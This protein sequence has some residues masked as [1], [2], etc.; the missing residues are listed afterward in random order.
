MSTTA[1]LTRGTPPPCARAPAP[2]PRANCAMCAKGFVPSGRKSSRKCTPQRGPQRETAAHPLLDSDRG[3]PTTTLPHPKKPRPGPCSPAFPLLPRPAAALPC[4]VPG[5]RHVL[6][7]IDGTTVLCCVAHAARAVTQKDGAGKAAGAGDAHTSTAGGADT[8]APAAAD[9]RKSKE[10]NKTALT[11]GET[12]QSIAHTSAYFVL[13][14]CRTAHGRAGGGSA[15]GSG[16][17]RASP[18]TKGA[19]LRRAAA[20]RQMQAAP[21]PTRLQRLLTRNACPM[22]CA[23]TPCRALS[24]APLHAPPILLLHPPAHHTRRRQR[25]PGRQ[26]GAPEAAVGPVDARAD[27]DVF[28]RHLAARQ[29]L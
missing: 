17:L 8:P 12:V 14:P 18:R 29:G 20:Q 28:R 24:A 1:S 7:S 5:Q 3:Y 16:S 15:V 23:C 13:A 4:P 2:A 10:M 21:P 9:G 22:L 25:G 11:D 26:L 27:D 19:T 6:P